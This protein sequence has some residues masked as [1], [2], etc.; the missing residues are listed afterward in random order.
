MKKTFV[1][2]KYYQS[3]YKQFFLLLKACSLTESANKK[4]PLDWYLEVKIFFRNIILKKMTSN[5]YIGGT[6]E[7]IGICLLLFCFGMPSVNG[8]SDK[9]IMP[10]W[11]Y[12]LIVL[13]LLTIFMTC[14]RKCNDT[15]VACTSLMSNL[16]VTAC[17]TF[18][19]EFVFILI[20]IATHDRVPINGIRGIFDNPAGVSL[21][22]AYYCLFP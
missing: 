3:D 8:F 19:I 9:I 14:R 4:L 15:S 16:Y 11:Y 7:K 6:I 18:I 10:K 21:F 13:S 20:E 22:S 2:L 5:K 12:S 17:I 1:K